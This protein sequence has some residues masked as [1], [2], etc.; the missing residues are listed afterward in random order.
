MIIDLGALFALIF[1]VFFLAIVFIVVKFIGKKNKVEGETE[2]FSKTILFT[3]LFLTV[4]PVALF[5]LGVTVLKELMK[6][7]VKGADYDYSGINEDMLDKGHLHTEFSSEK[8]DYCGVDKDLLD[9]N[10]AFADLERQKTDYSGIN[11]NLL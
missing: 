1:M 10:P 8:T 4:P 9:F 3:I 2:D 11:E 5:V 7:N 6:K